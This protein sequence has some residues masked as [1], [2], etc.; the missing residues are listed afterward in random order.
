MIKRNSI[1][2]R[3][4]RAATWLARAIADVAFVLRY[5]CAYWADQRAANRKA[6][7]ERKRRCVRVFTVGGVG[8]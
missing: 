7:R 4:W 6:R 3:T 2:G 1:L 5:A 8:Y